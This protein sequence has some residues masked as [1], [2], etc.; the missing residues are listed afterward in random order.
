MMGI[1]L[2]TGAMLSFAVMNT[3]IRWLAFDMPTPQMVMLRNLLSLALT[4][5]WIMA[6]R[7]PQVLATT[8]F[9]SHFSRSF[10]GFVAMQL[11]FFSM[12]IMELT[13]ATALSFTTP[14]FAT[15]LAVLMLGEKAGWRRW[16]AI[17]ISFV[18]VVIILNPLDHPLE[19]NAMIVL[20]AS[21]MMAL[22]GVAVKSLSRTESPETIVLY[23]NSI[24]TLLSLPFGIYVWEPVIS[25]TAWWVLLAVAISSTA[26][27]LLMAYSYRHAEMVALM[28]FDFTRLVFTALFAYMAFGEILSGNAW[29]GAALIMACAVY[30]AH[31]EAQANKAKRRLYP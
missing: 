4:I 26:A 6:R 29:I 9:K 14:I 13:L 21:A 31:R 10:I 28:P 3:C 11:W 19:M 5:M 22:A 15:L 30:I 12:S 17:L 2:F 18:G 7:Q 16:A 8:R 25:F 27:H 24:M 23:M 20:I 1:L